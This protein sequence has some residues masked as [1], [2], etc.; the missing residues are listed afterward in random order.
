VSLSECHGKLAE[1]LV[2]RHDRAAFFQGKGQ[3]LLVSGSLGQ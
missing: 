1:I 2:E 3:Y